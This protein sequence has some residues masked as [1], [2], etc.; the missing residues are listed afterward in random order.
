MVS[1]PIV[2]NPLQSDQPISDRRLD[3]LVRALAGHLQRDEFDQFERKVQDCASPSLI[4]TTRNQKIL[5][6]GD[7]EARN[8]AATILTDKP[9]RQ[10]SGSRRVTGV[11]TPR[12]RGASQDPAIAGS[13]SIA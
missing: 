7:A 6:R 9:A 1:S 13:G 5:T 12:F 2:K 11:R 8:R 10:A 4:T 3:K